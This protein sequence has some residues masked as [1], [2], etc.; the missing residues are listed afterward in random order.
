MLSGLKA[1][2]EQNLKKQAELPQMTNEL[3]CACLLAEVIFAD[4]EFDE[5]EWQALLARLK[6]TFDL[7]EEDLLELAE[8]AKYQVKNANDLYQFT[9]VVKEMDYD[10]RVHLIDG[11]WQVAFADGSLD[12]HEEHIIRRICE[13]IGLNHSDFIKAKLAQSRSG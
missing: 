10:K 5:S 3:A 6:L 12:P 1:F 4:S 7:A 13:L 11:L 2:F 8:T 9:R